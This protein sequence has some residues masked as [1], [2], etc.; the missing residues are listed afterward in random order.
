MELISYQ[1]GFFIF[2]TLT[3]A[4]IILCCHFKIKTN[5]LSRISNELTEGNRSLNENY[6]D[7]CKGNIDSQNQSCK[8]RQFLENEIKDMSYSIEDYSN[9]LYNMQKELVNIQMERD[10]AIYRTDVLEAAIQIK[11]QM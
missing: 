11:K 8:Q 4:L 9:K 5:V 6:D 10:K 1:A 2:F 7:L 3:I